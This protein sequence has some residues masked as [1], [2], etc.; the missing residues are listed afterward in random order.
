[1]NS[2]NAQNIAR[3]NFYA[4]LFKAACEKVRLELGFF[5]QAELLKNGFYH[6]TNKLAAS[7]KVVPLKSALRLK[8]PEGRLQDLWGFLL[9]MT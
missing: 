2:G 3:E 7:A 1:M 6:S 4:N 5:R 9:N 8:Q